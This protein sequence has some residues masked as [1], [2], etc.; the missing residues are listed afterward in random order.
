MDRQGR[1]KLCS[2]HNFRRLQYVAT[3]QFANY[4]PAPK[5]KL[6][7]P[8]DCHS[9]LLEAQTIQNAMYQIESD[10]NGCVKFKRFH[11]EYDHGFPHVYFTPTPRRHKDPG[12][13]YSH[14][15]RDLHT[16]YGEPQEV[17]ISRAYHAYGCSTSQRGI[18][19]VLANLLGKR[20]EY[21]RPDRDYYLH[22][23]EQNLDPSKRVQ[24]KSG[25]TW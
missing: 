4:K 2:L 21:R 14:P 25:K 20:D 19:G 9:G 11:Y 3:V 1:G 18:M 13:C 23:D 16:P 8:L 22:M 17:I 6:S 5:L 7:L 24:K 12:L 10:L 15:G